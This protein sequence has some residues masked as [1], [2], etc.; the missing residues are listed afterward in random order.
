[1]THNTTQEAQTVETTPRAVLAGMID[2]AQRKLN[3]TER[4]FGV[5]SDYAAWD[6]SR[7]ATLEDAY[8]AMFG[9]HRYIERY[10]E[11]F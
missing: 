4:D 9:V 1:M 11:V 3:V 5:L 7:W 8:K 10:E 2:E 6:R